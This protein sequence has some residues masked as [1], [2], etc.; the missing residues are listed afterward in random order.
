MCVNYLM[1]RIIVYVMICDHACCKCKGQVVKPPQ[2]HW[3]AINIAMRQ[4]VTVR[5][6]YMI[7]HY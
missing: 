6:M 3:G 5:E 4:D 7:Q 2:P 1:A